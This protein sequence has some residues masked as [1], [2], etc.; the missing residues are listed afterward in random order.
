MKV[1]ELRIGNYVFYNSE[2]KE[3]GFVSGVQEFLTNDGKI[4]I[5]RRL[6]IF[7][8]TKDIEPI[9]LNED[10]LLKMGFIKDEFT[11]KFGIGLFWCKNNCDDSYYIDFEKD[12]G[13]FYIG[14]NGYGYLRNIEYVHELQNLYFA[15]TGEELVIC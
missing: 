1:N 12:L 3:F 4:A 2:R 14:A 11:L 15:L 9:P 7:Y 8:D 10:W 5:N 6:D 13:G